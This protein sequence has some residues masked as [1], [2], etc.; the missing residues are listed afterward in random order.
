MSESVGEFMLP[1]DKD[2]RDQ[3]L[4]EEGNIVISASAGTG[5]TYTTVQ[6]IIR[7]A[8]KNKSYQTFAAITF[9]RKAAKEIGN[10]LGPNKG[11][12]FVG[13]NDNFIWI[14][15][16]Q[17]FMYDVYGKEFKIDIK[18]DFSDE[19][20][21]S[22]FDEG[23]EKI[24]DTHLMCKYNNNHKNFAFQLALS[25][26]KNSKAA[27]RFMKAKYYR[28]YIDEF[29]DSDVDMHNFFMYLCDDLEISLFIVG[30]SKQSIYGWRG[31]YSRG[32]IGLFTKETFKLFNLWHNFRSNKVIQNY[33]NIFMKSVRKHYQDTEFNDEVIV[34]K[35][36]NNSEVVEYIRQWIDVNKKCA[37]LN[38]SNANA[39][40]W[41]K[42][43]NNTGIPF[44]Y[45]PGSPLDYA[46]LE[47]EHIWI[48]RAVANYLLKHRY[49]EYDFRD[50]IP[51]PEEYRINNIKKMLNEIKE[52]QH[53]YNVFEER[54]T[55][56]YEYLGYDGNLD[57]SKNEIRILHEVANDE[58]YVPTYNQDH[59]KLTSGTIH[60]SKGLEFDQVIINAQDYDFAGEGIMYLHYV[61]ISRPEERLLIIAQNSFMD[62]YKGYINTAISRTRDLGIEIEA[63]R[64]IKIIE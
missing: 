21:I 2:I 22:N 3:I 64:V 36:R 43:L 56:L 13:T 57:K 6:R 12:G 62:R 51:M 53:N 37:F 44:V 58:K 5:K 17:P 54:C 25:I 45:V 15:I 40:R 52:E 48:A 26:L 30:D 42:L 46:N 55:K 47:S 11:E 18:P 1:V 50:D 33:S 4:S 63:K 23:V 41:S 39:E 31:A 61:A 35:S 28:I 7:D 8:E 14:E 34:Y 32:F 59:F 24:K 16:I 29:Q 10:R 20:Q 49:S 27:R 9:T 60:S 38:F 19:N